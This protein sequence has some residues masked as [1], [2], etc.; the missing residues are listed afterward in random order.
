MAK[1]E[2]AAI[3]LKAVNPHCRTETVTKQLDD[4]ELTALIRSHHVVLDCTD[5]VAVR[6]QLNGRVIS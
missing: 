2:S 6:E 4:D 5:N 1:T 3:A